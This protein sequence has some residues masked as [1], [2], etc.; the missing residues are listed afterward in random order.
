MPLL[1]PLIQSDFLAFRAFTGL[2]LGQTPQEGQGSRHPVK[3]EHQDW[4]FSDPKN[5]CCLQQ[6]GAA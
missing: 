3:R 6:L 1:L 2:W 4:S 5:S